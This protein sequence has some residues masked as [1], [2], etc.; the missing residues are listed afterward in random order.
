MV[1]QI[2]K[3]ISPNSIRRKTEETYVRILRIQPNLLPFCTGLLSVSVGS[4]SEVNKSTCAA[5]G[6]PPGIAMIFSL[7]L[8][9]RSL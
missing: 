6:S 5:A 8:R 2:L 4:E 9:M 1:A 3:E 7:L